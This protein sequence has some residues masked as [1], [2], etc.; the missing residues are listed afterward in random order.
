MVRREFARFVRAVGDNAEKEGRMKIYGLKTC[1]TC[2][3]AV[4]ALAGRGAVLVDIRETPL[5]DATR[6]RFLAAFGDALVNRRSTTWRGLDDGA[7]AAAP[8]ALLADHPAL[9]KR[10]VIEDGAALYLG[11]D[12]G[13][14]AALAV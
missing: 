9:M 3:A 4:K 14:R 1:D 13:V 10:P 11:W 7:R 5:D 6:A 2:R 8:E 12:A